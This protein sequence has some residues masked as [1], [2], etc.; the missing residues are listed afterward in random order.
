LSHGTCN[1]VTNYVTSDYT[2]R[3]QKAVPQKAMQAP[4]SKE[5]EVSYNWLSITIAVSNESGT[6]MSL[7]LT[8]GSQYLRRHGITQK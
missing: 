5:K 3:R 4:A 8:E 7:K 1:K 2:E 6:N